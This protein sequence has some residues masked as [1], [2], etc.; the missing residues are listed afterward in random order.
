MSYNIT[1]DDLQPDESSGHSPFPTAFQPKNWLNYDSD[2]PLTQRASRPRKYTTGEANTAYRT[3]QDQQIRREPLTREQ[4]PKERPPKERNFMRRHSLTFIGLGMLIALLLVF[5]AQIGGSALTNSIDDI[6]YGN[7]RTYQT[8][9]FV[10]HESG[11]IPSHFIVIN[12]HG[13]IEIIEFP[14]GD[15]TKAKIYLG[16]QL[17]DTNADKVPVSLQFIDVHHNH[18][19][20]MYVQFGG[21]QIVFHNTANGFQSS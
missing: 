7:P 12:L 4:T 21:T 5:L 8:D 13:H 6:R 15:G 10:G 18:H 3:T 17:Y 9:A 11:K 16:P 2:P 14:G 19:P 20:D 1:N